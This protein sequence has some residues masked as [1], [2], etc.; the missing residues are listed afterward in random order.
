[1]HC[2]K[3]RVRRHEGNR[4]CP[5][6]CPRIRRCQEGWDVV[7]AIAPGASA[8]RAKGTKVH[9]AIYTRGTHACASSACDLPAVR[10]STI[11]NKESVPN[12]YGK[13]V[14]QDREGLEV[15]RMG[16][17][18]H[19]VIGRDEKFLGHQARERAPG[20]DEQL[21]HTL[22]RVGR[23]ICSL[24]SAGV[25][26]RIK[27]LTAMLGKK[28]DEYRK[29]L[30]RLDADHRMAFGNA[31]RWRPL[32]TRRNRRNGS[33]R[34]Q[35]RMELQQVAAAA[36]FERMQTRG[37]PDGET[38]A[39]GVEC[40]KFAVL[41]SNAQMHRRR[42]QGLQPCIV[43]GHLKKISHTLSSEEPEV[44]TR[45]GSPSLRRQY[46][47]QNLVRDPANRGRM[48][49]LRRDDMPTYGTLLLEAACFVSKGRGFAAP[50]Q[51]PQCALPSWRDAFE[52]VK[53]SQEEAHISA[54][55]AAECESPH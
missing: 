28:R 30:D 21:D 20:I 55:K 43:R 34:W 45:S 33:G 40:G 48:K 10:L 41:G 50:N 53:K 5:R 13:A 38:V 54:V 51:S 6:K 14:I 29:G 7:A 39:E 4:A 19:Q 37:V 8:T 31:P 1:M 16:E 18:P 23:R 44:P 11:A 9:A 15:W 22:D 12:S 35:E 24:R 46:C 3:P 36:E 49:R 27:K 25:R 42:W 47:G 52:I 17:E 2:H 26:N 32:V